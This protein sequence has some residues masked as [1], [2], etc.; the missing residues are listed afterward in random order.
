VLKRRATRRRNEGSREIDNKIER[1]ILEATIVESRK[2]L[3]NTILI[4]NYLS[5][6]SILLLNTFS[7]QVDDMGLDAEKY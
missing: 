7:L 1:M 4:N 5:Q 2:K 6:T 3:A